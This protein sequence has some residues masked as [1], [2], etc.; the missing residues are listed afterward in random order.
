MKKKLFDYIIILVLCFLLAPALL[1]V[2]LS[3]SLFDKFNLYFN[4]LMYIKIYM[5]IALLGIIFSALMMLIKRIV[6]TSLKNSPKEKAKIISIKKI[7]IEK[8]GFIL[9]DTTKEL[10]EVYNVKFKHNDEIIDITVSKKD[11]KEDLKKEE[12]P[13]IEYQYIKF[14][15][16]FNK[17]LNIKVHTKK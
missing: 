15:K 17:F 6:Y 13:Y 5:Y 11:I 9:D 3:C 4:R 16:I 7:D 1:Y 10:N 12:H 2:L 8:I 14:T